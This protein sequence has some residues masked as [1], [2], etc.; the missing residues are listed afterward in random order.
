L[1]HI[2]ACFS[3]LLFLLEACHIELQ[4]QQQQQATAATDKG[5]L[6][7]YGRCQLRLFEFKLQNQ[8]GM[9]INK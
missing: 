2:E 4:Q 8:H 6:H 7:I 3:D 1:R 9:Q 5:M